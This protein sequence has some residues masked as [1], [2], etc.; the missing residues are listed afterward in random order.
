MTAIRPTRPEKP[1]HRAHARPRPNQIS[2]GGSAATPRSGR[3][4]VFIGELDEARPEPAKVIV[5]RAAAVDAGTLLDR[6]RRAW[7]DETTNVA[8]DGQPFGILPAHASNPVDYRLLLI[9]ARS[10]VAALAGLGREGGT[11]IS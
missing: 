6:R 8:S 3:W 5:A 9:S 2:G 10:S 1:T 7:T 4:P 11:T